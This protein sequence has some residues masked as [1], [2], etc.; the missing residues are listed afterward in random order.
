MHE[1]VQKCSAIK[2]KKK[3]TATHLNADYTHLN[4]TFKMRH[5]QRHLNAR[6]SKNYCIKPLHI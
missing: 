4:E 1:L 2:V 5:M 3:I 6:I